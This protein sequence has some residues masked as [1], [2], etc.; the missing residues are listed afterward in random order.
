MT[1]LT[2]L[3]PLSWRTGAAESRA[4]LANLQA[5]T[6]AGHV[7]PQFRLLFFGFPSGEAARRFVR[8]VA[9]MVKSMAAQLEQSELYRLSNTQIGGTPYIGLG[10][11]RQGYEVLGRADGAPTDPYFQ[12]GMRDRLSVDD[13]GDDVAAWEGHYRRGPIHAVVL[14]GASDRNAVDVWTARNVIRDLGGDSFRFEEIGGQRGIV[15]NP[16][17]ARVDDIVEPFGFL[18]GVSQPAFLADDVR[19]KF[20]SYDQRASLGDILVA[21]TSHP[22]QFGTYLVYRKIEQN[23]GAFQTRERNLAASLTGTNRPRRAEML[24]AGRDRAGQ[25]PI[26]SGGRDLNDVSYAN[27]PAGMTCPIAAHVRLMNPRPSSD[28]GVAHAD[29]VLARRGQRYG[30]AWRDGN[31]T[32]DVSTR[33]GLL[34]VAMAARIEQF[35]ELERRITGRSAMPG[36]AG[37]RDAMIGPS[38]SVADAKTVTTR[39]GEYF[40]LPSIPFL[41]SI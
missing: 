6:L 22:G 15:E 39:G 2:S 16:G 3:A 13:I 37:V 27:D 36:V 17:G 29:V 30:P 1:D 31:R 21:E 41:R 34:F 14:L 40:F 12:A 33:T 20:V 23:V 35:V 4:L 10:L 24:L 11:S 32:D 26:E 38:E 8:G 18:D 19:S 25:S 9:S 5:N 28:D 7:R